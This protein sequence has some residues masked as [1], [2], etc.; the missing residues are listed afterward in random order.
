M[1]EKDRKKIHAIVEYYDANF[2][3]GITVKETAKKFRMNE[4]LMSNYFQ[5]VTGYRP[6]EYHIR[7]ILDKLILLILEDSKKNGGGNPSNIFFFANELG[8]KSEHGLCSLINRHLGITFIELYYRIT[9]NS[10]NGNEYAF[11]NGFENGSA[12]R[13]T[14]NILRKN[15]II[16]TLVH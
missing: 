1:T 2:D 10:A 6:K 9:N 15:S 13:N 12:N 8:Y 4:N 7:R 3:K 5:L 16:D 14:Q 11:A